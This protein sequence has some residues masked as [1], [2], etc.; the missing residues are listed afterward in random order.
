MLLNTF[1]DLYI[2]FIHNI[3]SNISVV[4][5]TFHTHNLIFNFPPAAVL[6]PLLSRHNTLDTLLQI[7]HPPLLIGLIMTDKKY[8][9]KLTPSLKLPEA[10]EEI[11][12][13]CTSWVNPTE[14]VSKIP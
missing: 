9:R 11:K 14:N 6:H 13:V 4:L 8:K 10:C 7:H 3:L 2:I 12:P 5:Y 1:K